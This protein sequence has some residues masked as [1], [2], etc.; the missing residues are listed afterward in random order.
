MPRGQTGHVRA[1]DKD[2]LIAQSAQLYGAKLRRLQAAQVNLPA[3]YDSRS[4]GVIG[5][6]KDQA[7]CGSC[8]DFSGTGMCEVA[9]YLAGALKSDGSG[10]L[11]EQYTL[12]C[13]DNGGC[14]GDDNVTVLKWAAQT[15][16]PLSSAYGSYDARRER[17]NW[18]SGM[19]LYKIDSWGFADD[20][21]RNG[22]TPTDKIKSAI[23]QFGC[24]GTAVA[25]GGDKFWDDGQGVGTGESHNI[26]HDVILVGWDDSKGPG[27]AWIMR[28]SWGTSWGSM[29]GFAWVAY[30]AYD[31]G[32]ETVWAYVKPLAPQPP[33][34]I[35]WSQ[36]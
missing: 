33:P 29:S 23:M 18:S 34:V 25:A 5:P 27:G 11:S 13:G 16:L 22:V 32:T 8:W 21:N 17:C 3:S 14:N 12:S 36:L 9:Q 20:A 24:V 35:D 2:L 26:D 10:A 1:P 31:I 30:G 15:G 6:I 19:Q 28:N 4:N 7:S